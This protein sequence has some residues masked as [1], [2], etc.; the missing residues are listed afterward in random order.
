M[1][2]QPTHNPVDPDQVGTADAAMRI[3]NVLSSRRG[4]ERA[5]TAAEIARRIGLDDPEG[6]EVRATLARELEF[7]PEPVLASGRG[8][9]LI[10]TGDEATDY[11]ATLMSR[12]KKIGRRMVTVRRL[13]LAGGWQLVD[14]KWIAPPARDVNTGQSR[15]GSGP[16]RLFD[17][18]ATG[19]DPPGR[20]R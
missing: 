6:T 15:L 10:E 3:M 9:Y 4:R 20:K 13:L 7:C 12:L 14:G 19:F 18:S 16:G 17:D 8:Y 11:L 2:N 5:I 1:D